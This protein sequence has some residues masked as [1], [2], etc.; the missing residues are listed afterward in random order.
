MAALVAIERRERKRERDQPI[1]VPPVPIL[2]PPVLSGRD[3]GG[4]CL[5]SP[6]WMGL[7]PAVSGETPRTDGEKAGSRLR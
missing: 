7:S 5:G 1:L 3:R 4:G 6:G 2:V